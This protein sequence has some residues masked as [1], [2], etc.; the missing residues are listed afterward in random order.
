[1]GWCCGRDEFNPQSNPQFD[2]SSTDVEMKQTSRRFAGQPVEIQS[3]AIEK[4]S[5]EGCQPHD[6]DNI[7]STVSPD[8]IGETKSI[9]DAS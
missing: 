9:G 8:A 7:Q 6:S 3:I 2:V 5:V 4:R 1:M